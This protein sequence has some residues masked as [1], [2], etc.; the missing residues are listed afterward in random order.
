MNPKVSVCLPTYNGAKYLRESIESALGQ[1]FQDIE[2]GIVDDC[3]SD[4]TVELA[5]TYARV[6]AWVHRRF[7]AF[8]INPKR[9]E[10]QT[11]NVCS[12]VG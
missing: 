1:T 10:A 2:L 11:I 6:I 5:R 4:E 12:P 7:A 3:S 9:A 8:L